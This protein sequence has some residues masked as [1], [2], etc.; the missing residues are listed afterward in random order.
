MMIPPMYSM[1]QPLAVRFD[2]LDRLKAIDEWSRRHKMRIKLKYDDHERVFYVTHVF[3][4]GLE[5][6]KLFSFALTATQIAVNKDGE[7]TTFSTIR[8]YHT[9]KRYHVS[10]DTLR[11]ALDR[12][13]AAGVLRK[14]EEPDGRDKSG[15]RMIEKYS[16]AKDYLPL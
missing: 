3:R 14:T 8:H 15:K 10:E 5:L 6:H 4:D 9:L 16:V 13:C 7:K 2:E 1:S 12:M 11:W